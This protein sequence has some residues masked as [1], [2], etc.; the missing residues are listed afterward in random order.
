MPLGGPQPDGGDTADWSSSSDSTVGGSGELA[1]QNGH[2]TSRAEEFP[3]AILSSEAERILENAKRKLTLMEGNL[4]RARSSI[5][6]SPSISPS[7]TPSGTSS[8][9]GFHQPVGGLYRSISRADRKVSSL[10]PR[11]TY[12]NASYSQDTSN[13]RHSRVQSETTLPPHLLPE[14]EQLSRS[15][16]AMGSDTSS[17]RND[18]RSFRYEPTRPYL[19]WR[20]AAS[21]TQGRNW[22]NERQ[23][24][25]QGSTPPL[26]VSPEPDERKTTISSME[27]FNVVHP[28][29]G[30]L[31]RAQSQLQVRDLQDQMKGLHIKISSLKVKTQ[32]DNIRRRSFQSLRASSPFTA[33]EQWYPS[34]LERRDGSR[35]PSFIT[36]KSGLTSERV[37]EAPDEEY[38]RVYE[39]KKVAPEKADSPTIGDLPEQA[40]SENSAHY[41]DGR[42]SAVESHYED[43][44]ED[45]YH[46]EDGSTNSGADSEAL[47]EILNEDFDGGFVDAMEPFPPI[48][49]SADSRPHEEREDAFDYEHFILHSA[50]GNYSRAS[51]LRS[52][53]GS[54]TSSAATTRPIHDYSASA[55]Q[56]AGRARA[57]SAASTSTV[58]TFTTAI[59]GENDDDIESVLYWDKKFNDELGIQQQGSN[60]DNRH[61]Q[62]D[63]RSATSRSSPAIG[64]ASTSLASSLVSTVKAASKTHSST[65]SASG[66]TASGTAGINNDDTKLLERLFNSLGKVCMD[67][68]TITTTPEYDQKMA[69]VLRRRLD[70]AR[71]VLDGELDA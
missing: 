31:T 63:S 9:L 4:N 48:P 59:E 13:N 35:S 52:S 26:V 43:A 14:T 7:P 61:I 42:A 56:D 71:R 58:A 30:P 3:S 46:D 29:H 15:V 17:F 57:N 33:V 47:D 5:R 67:L 11:P 24:V 66:P 21:G 39:A 23:P 60:N 45:L 41:T 20:T 51:K 62:S 22:E 55:V 6:L 12:S 53:S 49:Q 65:G 25:S 19:A 68:Q 10:R 70:A 54:S 16:S 34:S 37:N 2:A 18:E 8:S 50:L 27:D 1:Q 32:E 36:A 44:E 28:S 69:R 40:Y 38:G 64:S